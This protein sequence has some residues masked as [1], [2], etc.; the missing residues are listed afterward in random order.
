MIGQDGPLTPDEMA[1]LQA[2]KS[3]E[4]LRVVKKVISYHYAQHCLRLVA[5][6][7]DMLEMARGELRG[8]A[9]AY[10]II[11]A[12]TVDLEQDKKKSE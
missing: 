12:G 11:Q 9:T 6:K 3:S 10:N 1:F 2:N 8:L 5:V 4:F 7:S